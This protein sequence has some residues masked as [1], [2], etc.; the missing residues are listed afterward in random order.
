M[1]KETRRIFFDYRLYRFVDKY[2]FI[3]LVCC[4]FFFFFSTDRHTH[5]NSK[6][7]SINLLLS[8]CVEFS[9][10]V[11]TLKMFPMCCC[12][13]YATEN[14]FRSIKL[15]AEQ[16]PAIINILYYS[17]A[18]GWLR[19]CGGN[20]TKCSAALKNI[21]TKSIKEREWCRYSRIYRTKFIFAIIMV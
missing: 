14:L 1:G 16:L 4:F 8:L 9:L 19:V 6:R 10:L 15:L 2:F 7:N 5:T 12:R 13:E 3:R 21:P 17:M 20:N 11:L 18:R